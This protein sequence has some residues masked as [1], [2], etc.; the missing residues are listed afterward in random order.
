MAVSDSWE[1]FHANLRRYQ[2]LKGTK[3]AFQAIDL[4]SGAS[5]ALEYPSVLYSVEDFI[6]SA[7][8]SGLSLLSYQE[9]P[10][11]ARPIPKIYVLMEFEKEA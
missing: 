4:G 9:V 3:Y 11:T 5:D 1:M 2:R 10:Y 7:R 6:E 8:V